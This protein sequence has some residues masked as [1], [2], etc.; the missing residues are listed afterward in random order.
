MIMAFRTSSCNSKSPV[1]TSSSSD[2]TGMIRI[3][4]IYGHLCQSCYRRAMSWSEVCTSAKSALVHFE[5][6]HLH[7]HDVIQFDIMATGF[8][9]A[10]YG[11][12]TR[13][14]DDL[15]RHA[16]V[17]GTPQRMCCHC[18]GGP[19]QQSNSSCTV[20]LLRFQSMVL[21]QWK[22]HLSPRSFL[23]SPDI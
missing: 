19:A 11:I 5:Y 10:T 23:I 14:H 17:S 8:K 2:S 21:Y 20:Y 4:P 18:C 22:I 15:S 1:A 6:C 3:R 12:H 16:S 7:L 9:S 13:P